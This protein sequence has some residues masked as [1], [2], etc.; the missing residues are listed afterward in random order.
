MC[1]KAVVGLG[2]CLLLGVAAVPALAQ[3]GVMRDSVGATAAG[4]GGTDVAHSDNGAI[5]LDN[6]AGMANVDGQGLFEIGLDTIESNT[7]YSDPLNDTYSKFRP[8]PLPEI[9]YIEKSDDGRW[10]YG[11]GIFAPAGFT[12][13][14]TINNP[15]FGP[16]QHESFGALAKILPGLAYQVTDRLS[17]GGTFGVGISNVQFDGPFTLQT[18]ALAGAPLLLHVHGT[19]ATPVWS[20]GMQY[21]LDDCTALGVTYIEES[22]FHLNGKLDASVAGF[23]PVPVYSK[24]DSQLDLVWPRSLIFGV[25]HMLGDHQRV[26]ADIGWIDWSSSFNSLDLKL[27]SPS[28]PLVQA[29]VG[30]TIHDR[31]PLDWEDTI[32]VRLGYEYWLTPCDV[33]RVGYMYDSQAA[34][35]STLTPYVPA[36]LDHTF[37]VGYGKRWQHSKVDLAYQFSFGPKR[38]VGENAIVGQDFSHSQFD[39]NVHLLM[40]SWTYQ[41]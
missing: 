20:V 28:N 13:E 12:A 22:R 21:R 10:A 27:S 18:G 5:L 4:R 11:L 8:V 25:T 37:T 16:Q 39:T 6:P 19:D 7:H 15:I 30:P 9:S 38:D 26:S 14:Y 2:V 3:N 34:P 1:H 23:G 33:L 35:N 36:T 17:V 40:L 31:F 32:T 29:L 41:F 24:F